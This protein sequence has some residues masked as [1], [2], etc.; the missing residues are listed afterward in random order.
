MSRTLLMV[1]VFA[2]L[3]NASMVVK[4]KLAPSV[5]PAQ[6]SDLRASAVSDSVAVLTWTEVNSS[7]TSIA[8]YVIRYAKL[9]SFMW[10]TSTDVLTG[11]CAAPVY[12]STAAGGRTRSCV[13]NNLTPNTGYEVQLAAYT[14]VLNSTAVFGPLSN[15]VRVTTA[16]RIGPAIVIRPRMFLDSVVFKSVTVSDYGITQFPLRGVFQLGDHYAT[17]YDSTGAI[18]ARGYL[19]VT[20]P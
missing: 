3:G 18:V 7:L 20:K 8:R 11:G 5:V 16:Q 6:V 10:N 2:A 12:G 14:G 1:G 4:P 19:L 15:I 9:G 13:L 17:A